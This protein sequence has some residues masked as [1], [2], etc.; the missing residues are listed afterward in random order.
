MSRIIAF[1]SPS[2]AG[3]TT[4][5]LSTAA[6]L[7]ARRGNLVAVDLNVV[8]PS[9]ALYADL[10]PHEAPQ[11]ACLGRLLPV[12]DGGRLTIDQ[13][14]QRLL[15]AET[16]PVLPG[17]LDAVA[18]NR[19]TEVHLRRIVQV[20]ATR[21][22][23]VLVDLSG[24]L[25]SVGCLPLLELADVVLLV[26]GPEIASRFHTRRFV[27][28]LLSAGW[29]QKTR[30]VLNRAAGADLLRQAA[31]DIG[32]PVALDVPELRAMP[33][34]LE[35]GQIAYYSQSMLPGVLRF[36]AAVEEL[37]SLAAQGG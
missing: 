26:A 14:T 3:A 15:P 17:V 18:A 37:A 23:L 6:A 2:H 5:L 21:F 35:A 25:D 22:D 4:L 1:W 28:P 27:L 30:L 8:T 16:F 29:D 33:G 13:L 32:L 19:F 12:L 31:E 11:E 9:L 10:L 7:G 36:R 24:P 34:F 20:L